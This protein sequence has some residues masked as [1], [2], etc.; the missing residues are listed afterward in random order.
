MPDGMGVVDKSI[1]SSLCDAVVAEVPIRND[2]WFRAYVFEPSSHEEDG[3]WWC[4]RWHSYACAFGFAWLFGRLRFDL[5][6]VSSIKPQIHGGSMR[7]HT[8]TIPVHGRG[9]LHGGG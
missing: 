9:F 6:R 8:K 3:D 7:R 4:S 5:F 1:H 2:A